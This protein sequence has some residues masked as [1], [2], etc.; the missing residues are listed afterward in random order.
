MPSS[1][2]VM[3]LPRRLRRVLFTEVA[4]EN[5]PTAMATVGVDGLYAFFTHTQPA[6]QQMAELYS[7]GKVP[8][9]LMTRLTAADKQRGAYAPCP[10]GSGR[11]FRFCHGTRDAR[12]GG[13][14]NGGA[15]AGAEGA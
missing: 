3:P 4:A 11:K 6:M 2:P 15:H 7:Q 1:P 14:G 12:T 10:C 5:S 9:E 13:D 8:A